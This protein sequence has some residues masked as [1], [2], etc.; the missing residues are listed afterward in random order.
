MLSD[1]DDACCVAKDEEAPTGGRAQSNGARHEQRDTEAISASI[2]RGSLR[3]NSH[4]TLST[5]G[6]TGLP[7]VAVEMVLSRSR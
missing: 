1:P 2:M 6:R 5:L 3:K 4:L 7:T